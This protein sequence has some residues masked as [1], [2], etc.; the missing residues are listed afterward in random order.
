MYLLP[1]QLCTYP[2]ALALLSGPAGH[3]FSCSAFLCS[4]AQQNADLQ[5]QLTTSQEQ[6]RITQDM[7]KATEQV[8]CVTAAV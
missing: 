1:A 4:L 5:Q 3:R 6:L 8:S 2:P 7:L